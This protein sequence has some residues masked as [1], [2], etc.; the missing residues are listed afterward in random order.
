MLH[1]RSH[2][3]TRLGFW[4]L[5]D[6]AVTWPERNNHNFLPLIPIQD[7][8]VAMD[9]WLG[10]EHISTFTLQERRHIWCRRASKV[11]SSTLTLFPFFFSSFLFFS[12]SPLFCSNFSLHHH[13]SLPHPGHDQSDPPPDSTNSATSQSLSRRLNLSPH[14]TVL[15]LMHSL[16]AA[17]LFSPDGADQAFTTVPQL[18]ITTTTAS[19]QRHTTTSQLTYVTVETISTTAQ[20]VWSRVTRA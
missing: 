7:P 3:G 9:S 17:H 5:T 14:L 6:S 10:S 11:A 16:Q 19:R 4:G 1:Q 8:S 18:K 2:L 13:W 15:S 12:S 20:Q